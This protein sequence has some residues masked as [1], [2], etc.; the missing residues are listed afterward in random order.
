MIRIAGTDNKR[1]LEPDIFVVCDQDKLDEKGCHGAPDWV[2]EVVSP[3][4][5]E[6]DYYVKL[7]LYEEAGVRLYWLV[8]IERKTIVFMIWNMKQYRRSIIL[9]TAYR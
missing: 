6:M 2:I 1:Y 9:L 3:G 8:D 5:R 4:S 7:A